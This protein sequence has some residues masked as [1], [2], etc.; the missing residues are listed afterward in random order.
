VTALTTSASFAEADAAK[1]SVGQVAAV[2]FP[3]VPSASATA[4]VTSISPTGTTSNGVVTYA[5]TITLDSPPAGVRLGQTADVTVTTAQVADVVTLPSNAVTVGTAAADGTTTG[6]GTVRIVAADG[7]TTTTAVTI[8]LQGDSTTQ[9][10]SGVAAGDKVVVSLDTAVG[11]TSTSLQ[12]LRN[13]FGGAGAFPGGGGL[14]GG[15]NGG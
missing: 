13:S 7:T 6:T 2:T 11:T 4:E 3:A 14:A 9:I 8:G 15:R 10:V 1:L 12:Q 5:A